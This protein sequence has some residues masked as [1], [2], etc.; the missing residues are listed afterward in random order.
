MSLKGIAKSTLAII[1]DGAYIP[2][3]GARISIAASLS[4]AVEGTQTF[5][6]DR[7]A[8]LLDAS[9]GEGSPPAITATGERTQEAAHRLVTQEGI[10]DLVLLNFASARNP[11]GGFI[12]GA[13][14]QEEDLSRCSGLYACLMPQRTYYAENEPSPG[15]PV[16][17]MLYTDH[18]IHSPR[19]PFFRRKNR[20]LLKAPFLASVI[21]APAPNATQAL[22]RD[23]TALPLIEAALRH[24]AG[25]VLAVAQDQGHR[26][27]LLG[28]WG[29]GV[30][31]N[32]PVIVASAFADWLAAPRFAGAFDRVIFAVFEP[33]KG[34]DTLKSFA[35]ISRHGHTPSG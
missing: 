3:K 2:P 22:R 12:K 16:G 14:A 5:T 25:G 35:R 7:V 28:A 31:G 24:R 4:A 32:P 19:V 27:L 9:G 18:I 23:P 21:T 30:F 11:G 13:K 34:R 20:D 6:P 17:G 8:A 26:S 29:C 10:D 15:D 33:V 1:E